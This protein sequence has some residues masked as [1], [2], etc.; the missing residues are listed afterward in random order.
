MKKLVKIKRIRIG[1]WY[2][3]VVKWEIKCRQFSLTLIP[4]IT[5]NVYY[6]GQI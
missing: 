5:I 4:N 2:L 3:W 6:Y 1:Q